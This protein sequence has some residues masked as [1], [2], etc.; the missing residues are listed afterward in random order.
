MTS[1]LKKETNR[2]EKRD[3]SYISESQSNISI[4]KKIIQ[5]RFRGG[6]S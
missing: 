4:V 6:F 1:L 5:K 2:L 3:F